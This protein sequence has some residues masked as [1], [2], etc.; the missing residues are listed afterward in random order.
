MIL[1]SENW[2]RESGMAE[3]A[4]DFWVGRGDKTAIELFV[5]GVQSFSIDLRNQMNQGTA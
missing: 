4:R 5:A 1:A 3:G 2:R